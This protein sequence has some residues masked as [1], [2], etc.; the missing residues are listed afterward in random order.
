MQDSARQGAVAVGALVCVGGPSEESTH[1]LGVAGDSIDSKSESKI[2]SR[3]FRS[4][5]SIYSSNY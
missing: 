1:G 2:S 3:D 4:I 5:G